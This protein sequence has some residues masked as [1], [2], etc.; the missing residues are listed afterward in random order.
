MGERVVVAD[1]LAAPGVQLLKA[2]QGLDVVET[3]GK[4]PE[5]LREALVDAAALVVR[6]ET[7]VTAEVMAGASKLRVV[8]RAGIG[9]DNIDVA[10][11]TR[12]GIAVLTAPGA[13]STSAA[14]H[15]F[16]LLLALARKVPWA[17]AS[18][19][20]GKWERKAYEGV[21]LRGKTLGILGLGRIGTQVAQVARAFGMTVVALD[22]YVV[23]SHA[24]AL[25]VELLPLEE[26]LARADVISLHLAL[27]D[28]T[29]HLI[30]EERLKRVKRGALLVNTARGALIDDAALARALAEG[31]LA[32]AALDVFDPEP[33]PLDSPLRTAP[34]IVLTPHLGASTKEAQTR[35]A[36]EI[37]EATRDA[38]LSGDFRSAV[39]LPGLDAAQLASSRPLMDLG[40]RLGRLAVAL[41]SG[42]VRAVDV[43][44][45]GTDDRAA[46]TAGIAAL[47]GVLKAMGIERVSLVNAAH[48]ARQRGIKVTRRAEDPGA[49]ATSL[50]VE[51]VA[52][53][54]RQIRVQGALLGEAPRVVAIGDHHVDVEPFGA[55]LLLTNR[56]VPGVVGKVGT[57]LGAAGLNIRDYHQSRPARQGGDA[58]AAIALEVRAPVPVLDELRRMPEV[59]GVW[60]V[61][62]GAPAAH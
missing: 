25:G 35:V 11:A 62:L 51:I 9:V 23:A 5:A 15:T 55:I 56:D 6:S 45:H 41:S 27:T 59:T 12:R 22:P 48:L 44:Y 30:N 16:A 54:G 28:D 8:A 7:K 33:L 60:Q 21:E 57:L 24:S 47:S 4:G 26:V 10:E 37:A 19:A 29:R 39:N 18:L 3:V 50:Y 52:D 49:F 13:N 61:D 38:L 36:I 43:A 14:E 2:S 46:D 32:G 1:R 17:A 42:G 40:E 31:R 34:N 58:L 20:E 53:G